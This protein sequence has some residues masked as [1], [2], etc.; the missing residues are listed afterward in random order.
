MIYGGQTLKQN[1]EIK[2]AMFSVPTSESLVLVATGAKLGEGFNF[3]RLDTLMLAAPVKFE[4]RL[5]QYVGRLNR[6]FEGKTDVIVYDYVDPHIRIFDRQ[7]RSRLKTYRK[8]G[9]RVVSGMSSEKQRAN[10]IFDGQDYAEVFE[11]DLVE[12]EKSIVIA[13]PGLRRKKVER[14][15]KVLQ[16]RLEAGVSTTVITL[17]PDAVGYGDTLELHILI[18]EMKRAG[19][20]VKT[21]SD[22]SEHF[23]VI[24]E[25]LV[26]HGGMNLLGEADFYDNL[27]RVENEQAA[28]ELLEMADDSE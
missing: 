20:I 23:A 6:T 15:V 14:L 19:I 5:V 12:A 3:P 24:D 1:Q 18:D 25:K 17:E 26:W 13:S 16:S 9:Y 2:E 4:G 21:T 28:A 22:V 7:Y 10:V 8:L 11:R 27:I